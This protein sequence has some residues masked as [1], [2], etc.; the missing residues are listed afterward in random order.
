MNALYL[1]LVKRECNS[2]SHTSI[3]EVSDEKGGQRQGEGGDGGGVHGRIVS[4][5]TLVN[6]IVPIPLL[7]VFLEFSQERGVYVFL[8]V[9]IE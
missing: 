5:I 8:C 7:L 3:K 1:T 6:N 9:Y 4:E 2:R